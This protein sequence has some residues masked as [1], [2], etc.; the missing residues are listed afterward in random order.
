MK[1]NLGADYRR[2]STIFNPDILQSDMSFIDQ[3]VGV[4][5][6]SYL[7]VSQ[8]AKEGY[9][10]LS[11]PILAGLPFIKSFTLN[12]GLRYSSYNTSKGGWTYKIL[13]DFEID[14]YVRLRGGYNLAAN[15]HFALNDMFS[16]DNILAYQNWKATFGVDD[17]LSP[18]P[19][20][21]GY[22]HLTHWNWSE[23]L[24]LNA[25]LAENIH[26][27]STH[28]RTM[29]ATSTESSHARNVGATRNTVATMICRCKS[30]GG[31]SSG[32]SVTVMRSRSRMK[33]TMPR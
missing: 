19:L 22:N 28:T 25:K 3:V 26:A 1:V 18:I 32:S 10:E 5:P 7:N 12:P 4:Y 17:D 30:A 21:G 16:V 31:S 29:A 9:G 20:S 27:V 6:E 15:A 23:E 8:D 33:S 2:D 11:I 24:R 13:G 14:D